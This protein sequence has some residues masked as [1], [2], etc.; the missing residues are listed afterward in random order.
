MSLII[1][2]QDDSSDTL[3]HINNSSWTG[4]PLNVTNDL[5]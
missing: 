2:Q 5:P 3:A 4:F 1:S